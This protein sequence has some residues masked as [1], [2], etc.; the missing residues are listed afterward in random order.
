MKNVEKNN[1]MFYKSFFNPD[2]PG[3]K[4]QLWKQRFHDSVIRSNNM[5]WDK[6]IYIHNNPV[7]AGLVERPEHYKY[8]S[9]RNYLFDDHSVLFVDTK[10]GGIDIR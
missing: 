9:A 1:S 8:S 7:E 5:F 3:R 6:V 10:F 2:R 4:R